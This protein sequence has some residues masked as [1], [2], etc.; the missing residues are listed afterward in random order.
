MSYFAR[1]SERSAGSALIGDDT[2]SS[3]VARAIQGDQL[4]FTE[5]Y[6]R[7]VERVYRYISL[8]TGNP[9]EAEDTVSNVFL[10]AW[11]SISRFKPQREASFA[12]WLFR[13]AHNEV[14]DS[15][16]RPRDL[17][18]LDFAGDL[19]IG[20]SPIGNPERQIEWRLTMAELSGALGALTSEQREVILLRFVED[21]SAREVG[22]IMGKREGTVRGMQF[23][24]IE[25]LRRALTEKENASYG[26]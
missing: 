21:L 2:E 25:A 3:L 1:Y 20:E 23:R 22:E 17:V 24:A 8:R 26:K 6:E 4:A 15:Y 18:S 12:A 10:K 7:Y 9:I 14:V 11:R 19:S 16:R 13:L 5:L